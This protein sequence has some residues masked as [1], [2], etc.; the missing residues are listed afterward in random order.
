MY[1]LVGFNQQKEKMTK[2]QAKQEVKN[3]VWDLLYK[4]YIVSMHSYIDKYVVIYQWQN[5]ECKVR[6]FKFKNTKEKE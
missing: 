5:K 2:N 4:K 6:H 1:Q 3:F